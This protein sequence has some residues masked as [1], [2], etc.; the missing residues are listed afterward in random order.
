MRDQRVRVPTIVRHEQEMT[1]PKFSFATQR[2]LTL[3][4]RAS[5]ADADCP[6]SLQEWVRGEPIS[7][8][9][10]SRQRRRHKK[11]TSTESLSVGCSRGFADHSR[12][13]SLL[14]TQFHHLCHHYRSLFNSKWLCSCLQVYPILHLPRGPGFMQAQQTLISEGRR[15]R[16]D[17]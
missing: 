11:A 7:V 1:T 3:P 9:P 2:S 16:G 4:T 13:S 14:P 5:Y 8:S 17:S 15:H 10:S 6:A 12:S